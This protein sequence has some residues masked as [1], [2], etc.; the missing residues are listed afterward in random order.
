MILKTIAAALVGTALLSGSAMAAEVTL[1]VGTSNA[2]DS[3]LGRAFQ[4]TADL[5][6]AAG[7]G[8]ELKIFPSG[9]LGDPQTQVK[10]V[11]LGVQDAFFEDLSWWGPYSEDLRVSGVPFMFDGREH[12]ERW[13]RSDG[14]DAISEEVTAK[15]GQHLLIGDVLWWRGPYRV[16]MS[17]K[18]FA[19]LDDLAGTK[20]R[21]P[22]IESLTRFWGK[23]GLGGN[24]VNIGWGDVYLA[25]RQGAADAVTLPLD[26]VPSMK[27]VEVAKNIVITDAFPQIL[28]LGINQQKWDSM[29]ETQRRA[30]S[31]AIDEGGRTY[32]T[33]L[34]ASVD[35]WTAELTTAGGIFTTLDRAPFVQKVQE[36][37]ERF[38]AKG[39][40]SPGLI[41]SIDALR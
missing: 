29:D 25:L 2:P 9:Q 1:R 21:M 18:P 32:N 35:T 38:E 15:G 19:T 40:W 22:A 8:L 3:A 34:N 20:L 24:V 16:L 28:I 5:V 26:L 27:F 11:E 39:Y 17:T 30:L 36:L 4:K 7:V 10:N 14:F 33:E 37:N 31:E 12:F 13:L 6:A 41:E 23:D